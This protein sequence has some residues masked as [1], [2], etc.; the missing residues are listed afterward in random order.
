MGD[1]ARVDPN[2][3]W[4]R[5]QPASPTSQPVAPESWGE[6]G[7]TGWTGRRHLAAALPA[8]RSRPGHP[9]ED[10][11]A[12]VRLPPSP[13]NRR[14]AVLRRRGR[15]GRATR[16]RLT[17]ALHHA[18]PRSTL[19]AP[20][21]IV[22]LRWAV[23]ADQKLWALPAP[24]SPCAFTIEWYDDSKTGS[25]PA[26]ESGVLMAGLDEERRRQAST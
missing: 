9:D 26:A 20:R 12:H 22:D 11:A 3:P 25:A 5:L 15:A 2:D 19:P 6:A 16:K 14:A 4:C 18:R 17:A 8:R 1:V 13:P 24:G 23:P 21:R 7:L 10:P